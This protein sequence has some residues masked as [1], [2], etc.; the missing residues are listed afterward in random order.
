M[1][2]IFKWMT[3]LTAS[4]EREAGN[5]V[6]DEIRDAID[7]LALFVGQWEE[8]MWGDFYAATRVG[9]DACALVSWAFK[10]KPARARFVDYLENRNPRSA[11][12]DLEP[13]NLWESDTAE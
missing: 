4:W 8:D 1:K 10:D 13:L 11:V 2:G 7:R 5:N 6:P 9:R 3:R 12:E